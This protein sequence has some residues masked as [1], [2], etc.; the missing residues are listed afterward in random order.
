M[1]NVEFVSNISF[2]KRTIDLVYSVRFRAKEIECSFCLSERSHHRCCSI[3]PDCDHAFCLECIRT[4]RQKHTFNNEVV[5]SC[6]VC[7]TA[8]YLITPS[9]VWPQSPDEKE[10]IIGDYKRKLSTI[11]CKHFDYGKGVCPFGS[12][13][14]YAHLN[15]DGSKAY[16]TVRKCVNAD[17]E[18]RITNNLK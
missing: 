3:F 1:W 8:T 7:R 11:P 15:P 5:R 16:I 4:W 9:Y 14:F 17:A 10:R 6:P 13:C 2:P 12:S 18:V